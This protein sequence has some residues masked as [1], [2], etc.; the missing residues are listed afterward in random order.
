ML[1]WPVQ[2]R[3]RA[4]RRAQVARR[5]SVPVQLNPSSQSGP[6]PASNRPE[7]GTASTAPQPSS[8]QTTR[9]AL[10]STPSSQTLVQA[11]PRC[12]SSRPA[13]ELS[14]PTSRVNPAGRNAGVGGEGCAGT[15]AC[16]SPAAGRLLPW[17][18]TAVSKS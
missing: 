13:Q 14:P 17:Q 4:G 8:R 16:A 9:A 12:T 7:P 15:G 3:P 10:M 6:F 11:W 5:G 18:T 1:A 2:P